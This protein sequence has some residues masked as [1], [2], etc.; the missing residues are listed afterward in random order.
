MSTVSEKRAE[1]N[2]RNA[3]KSTGPVT[4]EGKARSSQNALKHGLAAQT[5]LPPG[6]EPEEFEHE[7]TRWNESVGPAGAAEE[8]LVRTACHAAWKLSKIAAVEEAKARI[9]AARAADER[10]RALVDRAESIGRRLVRDPIN[11]CA[12]NPLEGKEDVVA[13]RRVDDPPRLAREL[14]SFAEGVDW[15]LSRWDELRR[16][17]REEGFWHYP[18]KIR[19]LRLLGRRPED[20]LSD[21]TVR[22][23]TL[24]CQVCHPDPI[25]LSQEL[26]R[27]MIGTD[28]APLYFVRVEHLERF[29]P[30][31]P[32]AALADLFRVVDQEVAR[33]EAL[34]SDR[35]D[36]LAGL[37]R[38]AAEASVRIDTSPESAALHRYETAAQRALH[39]S[40][41]LLVKLRKT[42]VHVAASDPQTLDKT[43][44]IPPQTADAEAVPAVA[45]AADGGTVAGPRTPA[46]NE[47]MTRGP[48]RRET[49]RRKLRGACPGPENASAAPG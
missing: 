45:R 31:S 34:K 43:Q 36:E 8:A 10:T 40:L 3:R 35:L 28:G 41:D 16:I 21:A 29:L 23:I 42:G 44:V 4:P 25:N 12:Q 49:G 30:E 19:A 47:A 22:R 37:D 14:T 11:R 20:V 27:C 1:A 38:A 26:Y 32:E 6:I 18:E 39:R 2:R 24:D 33:L 48:R 15:V 13:E 5:H 46:P 7:L 17:L 9:A